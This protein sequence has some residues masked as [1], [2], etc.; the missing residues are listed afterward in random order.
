MFKKILLIL[1]L[2][3]YLL[4]VLV[5]IIDVNLY[6]MRNKKRGDTKKISRSAAAEIMNTMVAH[7]IVPSLICPN[8]ISYPYD[9][10]DLFLEHYE[11]GCFEIRSEDWGMDNDAG[12]DYEDLLELFSNR[13]GNK[14]IFKDLK[15]ETDGDDVVLSFTFN[16]KPHKWEIGQ[17]S[18]G[19]LS[20]D[21]L[22]YFEMLQVESQDGRFVYLDGPDVHEFAFVPTDVYIVLAKHDVFHH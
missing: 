12:E 7:N 16:G 1:K 17:Y 18:G 9:I 3:Y 19:H 14:M 13:S 10:R 6:E 11:N 2:P 8:K 5:A 22:E 4:E 20:E 21:F 15:S